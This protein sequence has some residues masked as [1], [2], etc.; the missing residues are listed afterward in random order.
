M[1]GSPQRQE[2]KRASSQAL[3]NQLRHGGDVVG[4]GRLVGSTTVA[5]HVATHQ[6]VSNLRTEIDGVPPVVEC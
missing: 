6:A 5:Y 3:L 4:N 1:Q 2:A